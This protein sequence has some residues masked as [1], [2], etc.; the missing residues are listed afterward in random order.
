[1]ASILIIEDSEETAFILTHQLESL[2]CRI[3]TTPTATQ[4]LVELETNLFDLVLMD[5]RLP[6][7]D[8]IEATSLARRFT[9]VPIVGLT[10][11][12][13]P[14]QKA[15]GLAAGMNDMQIKTLQREDLR[16][17]L[18]RF[19]PDDPSKTCYNA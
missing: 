1:M 4:G 9:K 18:V 12:L 14:T 7:M 6:D 16:A 15:K 5:L 10:A 3:T 17:I 2:G 19:V 13:S 11:D 8:G